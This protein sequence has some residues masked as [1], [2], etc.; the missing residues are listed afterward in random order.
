MTAACNV[1]V[2]GDSPDDDGTDGNDGDVN[3]GER[4]RRAR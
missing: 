2:N 3:G 4:D 1:K